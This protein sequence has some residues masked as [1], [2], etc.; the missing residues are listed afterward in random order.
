MRPDEKKRK[1]KVRAEEIERD[2]AFQY[3][4]EKHELS[5]NTWIGYVN[6][7]QRYVEFCKLNLGELI[8]EAQEEEKKGILIEKRLIG[9]RLRDFRKYLKSLKLS[10]AS[11]RRMLAAVK[12]FYVNGYSIQMPKLG[13]DKD[14]ASKIKTENKGIPSRE[15]IIKALKTADLRERC[16]IL[17]ISSSG[18]STTDFV[19]LRIKDFKE[20]YDKDTGITVLDMRRT[21]TQRDFVTFFSVEATEAFNEYLKWRNQEKPKTSHPDLLKGWEKHVVYSEK[22][23]LICKKYVPEE[24]LETRDEE[25]RRESEKGLQTVFRT[26]AVRAGI[27]RES[28]VWNL[29]RAH[30]LRSWFFSALINNKCP[31]EHAEIFMAHAS[32]LGSSTN[33]TYYS[34]NIENLKETY[35]EYMPHLS[36]LTPVEV[37]I[38]ETE[39]YRELT[40]KNEM[41]EKKLVK[42]ESREEAVNSKAAE[43]ERL[44]AA[45]DELKKKFAPYTEDE[46]GRAYLEKKRTAEIMDEHSTKC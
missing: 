42:L 38:I 1:I 41:L 46:E 2:P 5:E 15:D 20:G 3:Y 14:L 22:D 30:K 44:W 18:L 39:G 33:G 45:I 34:L 29:F 27:A 9:G 19:D 25:L 36:L 31:L 17:G 13:R 7:F 8:E 10:P 11:I 37:R 12:S 35:L 43:T 24:Y 6:A 26:L 28:G 23:Y 40:A 16:I 32:K 21:K 4:K